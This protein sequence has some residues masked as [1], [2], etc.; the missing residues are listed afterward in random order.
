MSA[1]HKIDE[2]LTQFAHQIGLP[3]LPLVNNE[4][5]LAFDDNL[6]VHIIFHSEINAVQ[7]EAEV[8]DLKAING[9]LC[10]SLLAFNNHWSDFGAFFGLDNHREVL[11]LHKILNI[12]TFDYTSFESSLAELISQS[13]SWMSLLTAFE[14]NDQGI[15]EFRHEGL[16]I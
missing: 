7:L 10:R 15:S 5:S 2:V 13:E 16:K 9:D 3:E 6:R 14:N 12:E 11:C 8:V 4:L 1:R